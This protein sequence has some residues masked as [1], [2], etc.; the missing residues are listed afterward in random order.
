MTFYVE[1]ETDETFSN[2]ENSFP[3][4]ETV[5]QVATAVLDM[6]GC[7]Y[8]IQLNVLL[9][10]NDG[11]H[12]YNKEYRKIDRETDVLS[13]PNLDFDEP[14]DC[15]ISEDREAEYYDPET[16]RFD[17][18]PVCCN[19]CGPGQRAGGKLWTQPE[20]RVRISGRSQYASSVW[21]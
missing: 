19:D 2:G 10:D 9:T 7:P 1:N 16:R 14:G 15:E 5:E 17:A 12:A 11:I 20:E 18:Q 3:I 6:E 8:E 21:L 13:F 4:E